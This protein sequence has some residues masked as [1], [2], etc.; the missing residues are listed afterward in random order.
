MFSGVYTALITPF[1]EDGSL[2]MAAMEALIERQIAAGVQGIVP[3]GTTGEAATL[4]TEEQHTIFR[5]AVRLAKGRCKVM[6]GAGAND[7]RRTIELAQGAEACG[8]DGL[9][10]VTPYYNKPT[11]AGLYA[12]YAA[13]AAA[14][15]VPVVLYNVPGRTA[16]S[17]TVDT[18]ERLAAIDNIVAIKEATAD[19]I[20]HSALVSRLGNRL[21]LLSGDDPTTL[22]MWA[23]GGRGVISVTSNLL[24]ERMVAMWTAYEQGDLAAARAI[25]H[26]LFP[27]FEGLFVETNPVPVKSLVAWHTGLCTEAVRLPLSPLEPSSVATL[28]ALA[29]AQ[30]LTVPHAPEA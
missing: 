19:L 14:V 11:Q 7:T 16:C 20:F 10:V 27:W 23:V 26:Q 18:V 5:A 21:Q 17:L 3:C 9:L 25:H 13:V 6:A 15:N 24:P 12:H 8:V 29:A 30:G 1:K 4:T 2:D 22:P 28:K